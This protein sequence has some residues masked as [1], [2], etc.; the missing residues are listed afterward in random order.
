MTSTKD[1]VLAVAASQIGVYAQT[2]IPTKYGEWYGL[3]TSPWCAMFVSWVAYESGTADIIPKHAWCPSGFQ[4]YKDHGFWHW[5]AKGIS[6]GD[7]VYYDFGVGQISHTGLVES[8][9]NDGTF[10]TIEGNTSGVLNG[11]AVNNGLVARK[12]RDAQYVV[13]YGRPDYLVSPTDY[14]PRNADGSLTLAL[15]GVRGQLT[16]GRWQ[17]VLGTPQDGAISH[18]VSAVVIADQKFL[19]RVVGKGQIKDLTGAVQLATDGIE[20]RKTILVRQFWM[21]NAMSMAIQGQV[22]GHLLAFDGVFG[23]ESVMCFQYSL[24]RTVRASGQY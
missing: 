17:A 13:G 22:I 10:N 8:V 11:V 14:R 9:N 3:P 4:W 24:N 16:I 6:R 23:R 5:G 20:G 19:N 12:T 1:R 21:R 7:E 15:D 18:P 2:G